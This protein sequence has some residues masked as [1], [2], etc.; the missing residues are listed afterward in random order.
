MVFDVLLLFLWLLIT[1]FNVSLH[2]WFKTK[3]WWKVTCYFQGKLLSYDPSCS[4]GFWLLQNMV[5]IQTAWQQHEDPLLLFNRKNCASHL[6]W[7]THK[8]CFISASIWATQIE[9]ALCPGTRAD[10]AQT[11]T[12]SCMQRVPRESYEEVLRKSW[13]NNEKV[14]RK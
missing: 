5:S 2:V 1:F 9:Q 12:Y 14:M 6:R 10:T 7:Y 11:M 4:S 13:G 3:Y 8:K